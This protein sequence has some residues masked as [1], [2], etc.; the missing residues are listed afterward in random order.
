MNLQTPP[1]DR[2]RTPVLI[3]RARWRHR[4]P[5]AQPA[6]GA[7]QPVGSAAQRAVASA[8]T[9]IAA[10]TSRARRGAGRERAGL[11]R[12]PRPQGTDRAP[13]R[14]RRRPRLFQAHHDDLQR[15]DA[16]DR[17]PAAAGDRRRAGRRHRR[18]LPIGRELRSRGRLGRPRSSRR[19]ASTSACSARRRWWRCRAMS[20]AS[21]R[22]RCCSPATWSRPRR[23]AAIGLV[24]RVVPAGDERAK[25][26]RP[27]P[28][29]SPSKSSYTLKVGKEAFYRQLD[30]GLARGL[31]L[32]LRGDDR[33]HDG[34]RRRGGHLRLHRKAQA[35]LG[36]SLKQSRRH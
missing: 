9:E 18:R 22:W 26:A 17:Q 30:M 36:G 3:A 5:H 10:D 12:R 8:F 1:P 2:H 16:A 27:R 34:A 21:T 19:P 11:L 23:A 15:H 32:R 20:R 24:N 31:R 6:A 33:K 35:D 14:R 13:Q 7:Q 28:D 25:R 29:R 4:H